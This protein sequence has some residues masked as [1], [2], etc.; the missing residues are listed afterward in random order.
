MRKARVLGL[1]LAAAVALVSSAAWADGDP[2]KGKK[3]FRKCKACHTV[4]A[5]GKHRVGPNLNGLFGRTSGTTERFK[6]SKAMKAAAVVWDEAT[7][8]QYLTKPKKF[9]PILESF[10]DNAPANDFYRQKGYWK[11]REFRDAE[12]GV[13]MVAMR[14][15]AG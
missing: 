4:E 9:I 6:Y 7:I 13:E 2:A 14:K 5:G 1:A 8:D 11:T 15:E 3:I 10:R 12:Y